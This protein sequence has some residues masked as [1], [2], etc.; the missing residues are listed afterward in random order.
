MNDYKEDNVEEIVI[1]KKGDK[2]NRRKGYL[3][4]SISELTAAVHHRQ[5]P[6]F[7]HPDLQ[8]ARHGLYVLKCDGR[9]LL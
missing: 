7:N 2:D 9:L 5:V 1:G 3:N 6:G 8:N 4:I